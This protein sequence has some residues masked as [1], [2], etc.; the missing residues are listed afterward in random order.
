MDLRAAGISPLLQPE[1][2]WVTLVA[3]SPEPRAPLRCAV[4]W[5]GGLDS[6][7]LLHLLLQLRR[8]RPGELA[9]R[10]LHVDHHLQAAAP[11]FRAHCRRLARSWR[12]PL[13][14]LDARPRQ[15]A[16]D[17]LEEQA[18]EARYACW[19]AELGPGE[20]LLC[21]QHGDDQ[22]ETFL[23]AMLRG[24]GPAG[25]AAMPAVSRLGRGY[26]LRPLLGCRREELAHYAAEAKLPFIEDPTNSQPRFDRN[27]LRAE[28]VPRLRQRWPAV[29]ATASRS[30]RHCA[31]AAAALGDLAERDLEVAADGPDL[32]LAVLRRWSLERAQ[33]VVRAWFARAGMRSPET[34]HLEEIVRMRAVREDARPVLALREAIVRVHEGRLVLQ[35]RVAVPPAAAAKPARWQWRR[36]PLVLPAGSLAVQPDRHG[37]LDLA[38]LPARLTVHF[39]GTSPR[40]GRSLRKLLQTLQVPRWERDALPLLFAGAGETLLAVGDLWLHEDIRSGAESARK[41]RFVWRQSA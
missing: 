31:R 7:V 10:A 19:R 28:V 14:M 37:D 4:A 2:L 36:G 35:P 39:A 33:A 40:A 17:S 24:A 21:A 38:R 20:L 12:V 8:E 26:L 22:L 27:Y 6:S 13:T 3:L 25:L 41:G 15:D 16:G 30:A 29:A 34:R 5:S 32:E 11:L 23:L 1:Q 18:R 9:L